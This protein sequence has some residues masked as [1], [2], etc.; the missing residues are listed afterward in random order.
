MPEPMPSPATAASPPPATGID[1]LL[2]DDRPPVWWRRAS[3]WIGLALLAAAGAGLWWW[4]GR[5]AARAAPVREDAHYR[6]AARCTAA[7]ACP[8]ALARYGGRGA[9]RHPSRHG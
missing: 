3:L 8:T 2:G 9:T 5:Q 7:C 4:N 1:Q 6:R